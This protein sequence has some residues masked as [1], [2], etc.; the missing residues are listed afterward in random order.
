MIRSYCVSDARNLRNLFSSMEGV[1]RRLPF[2]DEDL[3]SLESFS[4]GCYPLFNTVMAEDHVPPPSSIESAQKL[5]PHGW[6]TLAWVA[7]PLSQDA[8]RMEYVP[9][10]SPAGWIY[11]TA[12]SWGRTAHASDGIQVWFR[13]TSVVYSSPQ[14]LRILDA[15]EH[16][17]VLRWSASETALQMAT[18]ML[19]SCAQISA[20][21]DVDNSSWAFTTEA[22]WATLYGT[23]EES[24][25]LRRDVLYRPIDYFPALPDPGSFT[26][27]RNPRIA[28]MMS[29][30]MRPS[31]ALVRCG[32]QKLGAPKKPLP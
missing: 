13:R 18:F 30:L 25:A 10:T 20:N 31:A 2:L 16:S 4:E 23:A 17:V 6:A 28:E 21:R 32:K 7:P 11:D 5:P 8:E 27:A 19:M 12:F 22:E 26:A 9:R 3:V 15:V 29:H 24:L 1:T 14:T